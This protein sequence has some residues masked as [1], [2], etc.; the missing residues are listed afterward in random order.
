MFNPVEWMKEQYAE[1][2]CLSMVTL[3][4]SVPLSVFA[5]GLEIGWLF[6]VSVFVTLF[7][8]V[9]FITTL[10]LFVLEEKRKE[11]EAAERKKKYYG[12]AVDKSGESSSRKA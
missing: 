7:A 5:L 12:N 11:T 8:I 4:L 2:F 1:S 9:L 10:V 6:Y 3:I